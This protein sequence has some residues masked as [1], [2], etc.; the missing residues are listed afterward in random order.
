MKSNPGWSYPVFLK[1]CLAL[2]I[3]IG[4]VTQPVSGSSP[5]EWSAGTARVDITPDRPVWMAGYA[6]RTKPS[7]GAY[8]RLF[9]KALALRD[10]HGN[11]VVIVTTDILGIP[12]SMGEAIAE[13]V[14]RRYGLRRA[15]LVLTSSHTHTGPVPRRE[16][17]GAYLID[18]SESLEI[19]RVTERMTGQII[20]VVGA[21]LQ[22]LSPATLSFGRGQANFSINRRV[23]RQGRFVFGSNPD[24]VRDDEVPLLR[25]TAPDGKVRALLF[26]Y[27]CHNTTLTDTFYQF[28]GDY[29][30]F[31]QIEIEK[32]YPGAMAMFMMGAGADINP[33]PRGRLDMAIR[34]GAS[35]AST[36]ANILEHPLQPVR[37]SLKAAY[38]KIDLPLAPRTRAEFEAMRLDKDIYRR[39][40]A[41]RWLARLDAGGSLMKD[42][43]YPVQAIRI[44]DAL[45]FIAL[46]GEVVVDYSQRLKS[47]LGQGSVW[48]AAYCND[49]MAYIPSRRILREGGYEADYSMLFYDLPGPWRP[50][51][52]ELIIREVRNLVDR[53][54]R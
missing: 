2:S 25:V 20:D 34:H 8:H 13:G 24:G 41:E 17:E 38:R 10:P 31:A 50:E 12:R 16:L 43:P 22:N 37:G 51:I 52:E 14:T 40:Y 3:I 30:G 19:R 1:L 45:T 42:Y 48:I 23:N 36:I 46:S 11:R 54:G 33:E 47:E 27:A 7:E 21:A 4:V 35:L 39:A 28:N 29:A 15:S 18:E 44:G 49:V 6:S 5:A 9:A 53:V 26:S 32:S